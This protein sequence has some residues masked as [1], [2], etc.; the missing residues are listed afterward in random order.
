[1]SLVRSFNVHGGDIV[2]T[3]ELEFRSGG[4]VSPAVED[5]RER[6]GRPGGKGVASVTGRRRGGGRG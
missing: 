1:V 2:F 4:L 6:G 3:I 5:V